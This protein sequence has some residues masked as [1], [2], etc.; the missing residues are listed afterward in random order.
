MRP[1]W[2]RLQ[3][4]IVG[5]QDRSRQ[6]G[7]SLLTYSALSPNH[8]RRYAP[9]FATC[10]S[11]FVASG[12]FF[13]GTTDILA[14]YSQS[15]TNSNPTS[16]AQASL[17]APEKVSAHPFVKELK[18]LSL[19]ALQSPALATDPKSEFPITFL[20]KLKAAPAFALKTQTHS[21]LDCMTQALYFEARGEG[22][23]GM[24]AVAQ[25]VLNRVRHRAFPKSVCGVVY[26]GSALRTGCQFTFACDGTDLT[27]KTI[28][29]WD[30]A[31]KIAKAA[32]NGYVYTKIGT[33]TH[34]HA[35]YV[36]PVWA[37]RMD[38]ITIIGLHAFYQFHGTGATNLTSMAMVKPSSPADMKATQTVAPDL[39]D[40]LVPV[41]T[42][43]ELASATPGASTSITNGIAAS[44]LIE[45]V[46]AGKPA[47]LNPGHTA[48]QT[49]SSRMTSEK[50]VSALTTPPHD[51][52][53]DKTPL[54]NKDAS[55]VDKS[56]SV[57][58]EK[59]EKSTLLAASLASRRHAPQ[60]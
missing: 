10:L 35:L 30:R 39:N 29:L 22:D 11:V 36:H 46:L 26:Q 55:L 23:D 34:Y 24:R 32:L 1:V 20:G 19:S 15:H 54:P 14:N 4:W 9:F 12:L 51:L 43:T 59:P 13:K 48:T 49:T 45:T 6:R 3:Y 60:P 28:G 25:V 21:D 41:P 27:P 40:L 16:P 18:F 7:Y 47:S 58:A 33:S 2:T 53:A 37:D 57:T 31:K 56:A 44:P 38:R 52:G 50:L 5:E 42:G 17:E 8:S